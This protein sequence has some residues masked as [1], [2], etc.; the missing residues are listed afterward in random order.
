MH[1]SGIAII[2]FASSLSAT[3]LSAAEFRSFASKDSRVLISVI[4]ELVDGDTERFKT[5][6][7]SA[8]DAGKFVANIRLN[9]IGGSLLEGV[10][11][12]QAVQFAKIA[13]NV[14]KNGICASACFLV[15]AAGSTKFANYSAKIGVHGDVA[16]SA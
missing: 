5:A 7:K 10:K 14:G 11:L 13:T 4:G 12:A 16:P 3:N 2:L 15:F 6:V 1:K 8:N 9:S